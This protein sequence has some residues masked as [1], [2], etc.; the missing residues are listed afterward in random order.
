MILPYFFTVLWAVTVSCSFSL[1]TLFVRIETQIEDKWLKRRSVSTSAGPYQV[2][3][4]AN[5]ILLW[6]CVWTTP[7]VWMQTI[8]YIKVA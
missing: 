6:E 5:E 7:G 2:M 4:T 8:N 3:A 1:D